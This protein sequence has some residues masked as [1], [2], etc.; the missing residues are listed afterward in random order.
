MSEG[1]FMTIINFRFFLNQVIFDLETN[2]ST[3][4]LKKFQNNFQLQEIEIFRG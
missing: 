1:L 2:I 4:D 3:P